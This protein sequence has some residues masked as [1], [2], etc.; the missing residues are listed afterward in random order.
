MDLFHL[1]VQE[2]TV[3]QE[4]EGETAGAWDQM[5]SAVEK[6]REKD[7]G[8]QVTFSSVTPSGTPSHGMVWLTFRMDLLISMKL[9]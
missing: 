4:R 7:V 9:I 6:Q 1:T 5:A 3:H 8:D 2:D